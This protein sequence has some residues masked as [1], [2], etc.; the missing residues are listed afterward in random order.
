[1]LI[2]SATDMS[3]I[4]TRELTMGIISLALIFVSI[5]AVL[6]YFKQQLK[7]RKKDCRES[8][9]SLRIALDCRHHA[10]R[11][12]LDAYSKHLQ[13]QGIASDQN[14]QQMCAE[15]ETAL[16]QTAKTF[17]ESKI[18]HLCETETALNHALKKLQTAVNSLLKQHPDE[19]LAGLMEMLGAA[20]A[21]VASAR[22]IYNRRAGS[23]NH[24]LNK[25]PNRLVAKPLGFDKQASLVRF[26]ENQT[27][28]MSSNMLV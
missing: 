24:H 19:K 14:V 15:V 8:F 17:S 1:M 20:E 12:V 4:I 9:V 27:Q 25:L 26:T 22:R 2:K 23:Y 5:A 11:H 16:A 21:E 18:K 6:L 28:R 13:E 3:G 7:D 10:V